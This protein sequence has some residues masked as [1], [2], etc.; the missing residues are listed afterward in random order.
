MVELLLSDLLAKIDFAFQA[1]RGEGFDVE[2]VVVKDGIE[3]FKAVIVQELGDFI[4]NEATL[5]VGQRG[6]GKLG[7]GRDSRR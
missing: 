7:S 6:T 5:L 4:T 1:L 2:T 3:K